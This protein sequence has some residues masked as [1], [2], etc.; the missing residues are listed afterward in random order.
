VGA[1]LIEEE[2]AAAAAQDSKRYGYLFLDRA[3]GA[4]TVGFS[5]DPEAKFYELQA[6]QSQGP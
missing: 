5:K 1:Y 6:W 2:E 4:F 3:A